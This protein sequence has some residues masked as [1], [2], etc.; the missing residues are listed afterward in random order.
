MAFECET[1]SN[2]HDF[3]AN[4]CR[5]TKDLKFVK[6]KKEAAML[7][8]LFALISLFVQKIFFQA[9]NVHMVQTTTKAGYTI[10][11]PRLK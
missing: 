7:S 2:A 9:L 3:D 5:I 6:I 11:L 8:S 1:F 4:K 10:K